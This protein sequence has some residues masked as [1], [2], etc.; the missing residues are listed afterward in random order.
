MLVHRIRFKLSIINMHHSITAVIA[1]IQ[2][3]CQV[4]FKTKIE[5]KITCVFIRKRPYSL[6]AKIKVLWNKKEKNLY[7]KI[8]LY[9]TDQERITQVQ[10]EFR[11]LQ[12]FN[13]KF[14]GQL[15]YKVIKPLIYFDNPP[16]LV[17]EEGTGTTLDK[18]INKA[19]LY[20]SRTNLYLLSALCR[21]C[22]EWLRY[23]QLIWPLAENIIEIKPYRY[24]ETLHFIHNQLSRCLEQRRYC[25]VFSA[26]SL[27][28]SI[29]NGFHGS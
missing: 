27:K 16:S 3:Q 22:G 15:K 9:I 11:V 14:H 20:P 24:E 25:Q 6:I 29:L 8:P 19:R 2:E 18:I 26:N 1:L 23:F 10:K 13:E 4:L 7:I 12:Y 28:G 5:P 21:N 17:T